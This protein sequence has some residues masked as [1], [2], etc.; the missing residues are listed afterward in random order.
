MS[1]RLAISVYFSNVVTRTTR[2]KET[3]FRKHLLHFAAT[4]HALY[5]PFLLSQV[6]V[7]ASWASGDPDNPHD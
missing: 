7:K 5:R 3:H 4:T 6:W 2:H 1:G